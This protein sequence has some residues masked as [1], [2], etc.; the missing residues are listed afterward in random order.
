MSRL[1]Q[2]VYDPKSRELITDPHELVENLVKN[3]V[4]DWIV[5]WTVQGLYRF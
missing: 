2:L 1:N 3:L 5:L 4:F